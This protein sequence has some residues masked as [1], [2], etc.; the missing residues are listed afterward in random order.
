MPGRPFNRFDAIY[1]GLG[2]AHG[3]LW[4]IIAGFAVGVL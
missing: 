4:T 2:F 1:L 3:A